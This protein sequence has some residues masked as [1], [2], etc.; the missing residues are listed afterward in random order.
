MQRNKINHGCSCWVFTGLMD[1]QHPDHGS[2]RARFIFIIRIHQDETGPRNSAVQFSRSPHGSQENA[3][4]IVAG[5]EI[6]TGKCFDIWTKAAKGKRLMGL[7][8]SN[9]SPDLV[10]PDSREK[11]PTAIG[12][13]YSCRP[14][15]A[16]GSAP[17]PS[18]RKKPG[19]LERLRA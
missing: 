17:M 13:D 3:T 16:R 15:R 14:C 5:T 1:F 11:P 2:L 18:T 19:D 8:K 10:E 6:I 7:N 4:W 12:D 9:R